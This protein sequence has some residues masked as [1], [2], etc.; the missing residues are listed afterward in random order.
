VSE[1]QPGARDKPLPV[2]ESEAVRKVVL[3]HEA[4][5]KRLEDWVNREL[6]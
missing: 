6:E 4:R 3:D 2:S 1:S 5:I